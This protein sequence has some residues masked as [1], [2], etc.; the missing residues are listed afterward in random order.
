MKNYRF[1]LDAF[2]AWAESQMETSND[3]FARF[4]CKEYEMDN[5]NKMWKFRL[6][7]SCRDSCEDIM[8][9]RG[10][11]V[12]TIRF[13]FGGDTRQFHAHKRNVRFTNQRLKVKVDGTTLCTAGTNDTSQR[14]PFPL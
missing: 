12:D 3:P 1:D 7:E 6:R 8:F 10:D 11:S 13:D 9:I 2:V 14:G 4:I 5:G